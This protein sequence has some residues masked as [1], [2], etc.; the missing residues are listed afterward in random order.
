M[1]QFN[2]FVCQK[3]FNISFFNTEIFRANRLDKKGC[4]FDSWFNS[5]TQQ[6]IMSEFLRW[7]II[8]CILFYTLFHY[9]HLF[10]I[11]IYIFSVNNQYESTRSNRLACYNILWVSQS[12]NEYLVDNRLLNILQRFDKVFFKR[13]FYMNFLKSLKLFYK[14]SF[15]VK[16]S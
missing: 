8:I 3:R 9:I 10:H 4:N 2:T 12:P 13:N 16:I 14:T 7:E 5:F 11:S 1:P 6:F 15:L